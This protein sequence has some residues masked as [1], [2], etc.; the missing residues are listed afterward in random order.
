MKK[1]IITVGLPRSGKTTWCKEQ[2]YPVVNP[3]AVR[4]TL[5]CY[6][7]DKNRESEVWGL[8]EKMINTLFNYGYKNV[9]L[10]SCNVSPRRSKWE[11]K[12]FYCEYKIF[13]TDVETCKNRAIKLGQFDLLDM[14]D[15]MNSEFTELR[16]FEKEY[17]G[18]VV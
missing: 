10:D 14:L 6:P 3:D 5:G 17:T 11:G 7:F 13:K 15:R 12:G 4:K 1:L 16:S 2:P 8:V 9:I 18:D